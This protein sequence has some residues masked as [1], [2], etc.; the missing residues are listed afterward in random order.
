MC[1]CPIGLG[2]CSLCLQGKHTFIVM[3]QGMNCR[4]A[5]LQGY[6]TRKE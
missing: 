2:G 3:K 6:D 4:K 1:C 5:A